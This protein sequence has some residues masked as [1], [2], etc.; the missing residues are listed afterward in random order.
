M[1]VWLLLLSARIMINNFFSDLFHVM[2]YGKEP[3]G[4]LNLKRL[5][6]TEITIWAMG[7]PG[8]ENVVLAGWVVY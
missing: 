2:F 5:R 7:V 3:R 6:A 4:S 1:V 8:F